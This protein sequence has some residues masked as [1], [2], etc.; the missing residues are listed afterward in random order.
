MES[1]FSAVPGVGVVY[2]INIPMYTWQ[3]NAK[4]IFSLRCIHSS[5]HSF[6]KLGIKSFP[7]SS[8]TQK[9]SDQSYSELFHKAENWRHTLPLH[10]SSTHHEAGIH[11]FFSTEAST[12]TVLSSS[13]AHPHMP[14]LQGNNLA[15]THNDLVLSTVSLVLW[16]HH[17]LLI[18][19]TLGSSCGVWWKSASSTDCS[20]LRYQCM[21]HTSPHYQT[22]SL[23]VWSHHI[24]ALW[25]CS[26]QWILDIQPPVGEE[27][28]W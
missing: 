6:L 22:V 9:N 17:I 20:I 27:V 13:P 16:I 12:N 3:D 18:L 4:Q 21:C 11:V 14:L 15:T 24:F 7:L 23:E 1:C 5:E 10:Q 26:G 8:F 28:N 25:L 2:S 19:S